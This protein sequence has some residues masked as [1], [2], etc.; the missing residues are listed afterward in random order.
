MSLTK[1]HGLGG[2]V[3]RRVRR[4]FASHMER[5]RHHILPSF[6]PE[7]IG[8]L[9]NDAQ[10][11]AFM[12][13]SSVLALC[14][15]FAALATLVQEQSDQA[16]A[17]VF[18]LL[19]SGPTTVAH[20]LESR[21]FE[22]IRY[23]AA[24]TVDAD[25]AGHWL[26]GRINRTNLK[27]SRRIWQM[28]GPG[29]IP[30][31]WQRDFISGYC[32]DVRVWHRDIRLGHLPGVDIKV[33]WE[34]ARMQHLPNLALAGH[35]ARLHTPGFQDASVY[36]QELRNQILDFIATNPPG[37]GVNWSCAMDVAIRCAN[38]LVARDILV[39]SGASL[40]EAFERCF[41]A[42]IYAH[43]RHVVKNLEW[44]PVYRGNHYLANIVGLL[45]AAAYLP[46]SEEVDSWLMFATQELLAEVHY[47][48]HEDGS[49]FE[50]SV[51]YH[52]LSAEMV[53]WGVAVLAGLSPEKH[54]VLTQ[55]GRHRL[56]ALPRL[57]PKAFEMH[58]VPGGAA[59][60]SPVPPWCWERLKRMAD[61]TEALTRPDGM[62]AQFGDN[63]SGRFITLISGEQIRAGND[64]SN[65]LWSL[66]HGALVAGIRALLGES[67]NAPVTDDVNAWV[68][69][70]FA[71]LGGVG[72]T[73]PSSTRPQNDMGKRLHAIGD[74][75]VWHE[76][77]NKLEQ[78]PATS[79]WTSRFETSSAGFLKDIHSAAFPGMG[80]YV[81]RSERLFL[82]VRCGEIGVMGLGAHAHCDQL[83]IELVIDG[84]S[85]VRDPGTYVY[86]PST[87]KR[88]AYRSA[89]AHHVPHVEGREPANLAL[90]LFDLRGAASGECL[91]AGPRGFIGRHAGYGAWVVRII[92]LEDSG[93]TIH[94]IAEGGLPLSSSSPDPVP[95]SPAYGRV[96]GKS[97]VRP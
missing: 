56:R 9:P 73:S 96:M 6:S 10:R 49:N 89:R 93:I 68:V 45:F 44:S 53:L 86:T 83:A 26:V 23:P 94:D 81:F 3:L 67:T 16:R 85:R 97:L 91:Y 78:A 17:H 29:Y 61:F 92:A 75:S 12:K 32:W 65:P 72:A 15:P 18:D 66:D 43:A 40:D 76:C 1:V 90:G 84:E 2:R 38:L 48:F 28:V 13:P 47:Q 71:G 30:I 41:A 58:A 88:N 33:P 39:A 36:E 54:S 60:T 5:V 95:F 34:L 80:C 62:V 70:G 55:P 14:A 46:K 35:F 82:A 57:R 20:G 63:D 69:K 59:R 19:G 4:E 21:G 37:F 51:C 7:L 24:P 74:D 27:E 42:S 52:R 25:T 79:R 31:D 77:V 64:P 50:A 11:F 8:I 22:S 87:H